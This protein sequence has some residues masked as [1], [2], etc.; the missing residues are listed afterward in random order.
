MEGKKKTELERLLQL[1][2]IEIIERPTDSAFVCVHSSEG[3]RDG[4]HCFSYLL[5]LDHKDDFLSQVAWDLR[6]DDFRPRVQW[7]ERTIDGKRERKVFYMQ[8]GNDS[9]AEALVRDRYYWRSYPSEVEV[10]EEFRLFWNLFHDKTRQILLHCDA[11]GT[12]H[13]VVRIDGRRVEVQLKFLVDFLLRN[14]CT[15]PFSGRV[16]I[17]VNIH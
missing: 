12:E 1:R 15:S 9:D 7:E 13:T 10:A 2:R 8:R 5:P 16:I 6:N 14:R 17:G 4:F 3:A 11:D